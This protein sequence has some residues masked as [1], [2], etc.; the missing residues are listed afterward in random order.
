MNTNPFTPL[1]E[2]ALARRKDLLEKL[3][4][5]GTDSYRLFHGISEGRPGLSV[6]RYGPLVLA[7]TFREP[8]SP[9]ETASLE[10]CL[11]HLQSFGVKDVKQVAEQFFDS[12]VSLAFAPLS[13]AR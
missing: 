10:D 9:G 5:E 2:K 1:L 4:S 12:Y 6:D 13:S 11:R 8:L 3:H 7:Q